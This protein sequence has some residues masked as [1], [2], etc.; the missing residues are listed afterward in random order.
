MNNLKG[1]WISGY[2]TPE[3]IGIR[4]EGLTLDQTHPSILFDTVDWNH[5][6]R[7]Y[8]RPDEMGRKLALELFTAV[9]QVLN[10]LNE[11]L[12]E[13]GVCDDPKGSTTRR[14]PEAPVESRTTTGKTETQY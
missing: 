14:T 4:M 9:E 1:G 2:N 6:Y 10:Y 5:R 13:E 12:K 3:L 7:L 11:T 8:F